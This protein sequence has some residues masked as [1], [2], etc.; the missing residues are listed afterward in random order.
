MDRLDVMSA[1]EHRSRSG[2]GVLEFV[3]RH[4][5]CYR[6]KERIIEVLNRGFNLRQADRIYN[7]NGGSTSQILGGHQMIEKRGEQSFALCVPGLAPSD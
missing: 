7:L 2:G 1:E 6:C 5:T 4:V 3:L